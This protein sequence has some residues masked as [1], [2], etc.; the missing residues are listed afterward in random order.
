MYP[1]SLETRISENGSL[2]SF[3]FDTNRLQLFYFIAKHEL[4][5]H[6]LPFP[7]ISRI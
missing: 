6:K 5:V 7:S 3:F 2:F 1:D 4:F